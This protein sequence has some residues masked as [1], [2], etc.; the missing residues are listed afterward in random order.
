[1]RIEWNTGYPG[2]YD[3]LI[4]VNYFKSTNLYFLT[5]REKEG[6]IEEN[7]TLIAIWRIKL[8]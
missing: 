6:G 7:E 1:M 3:T 2:K 8:K 4:Y 5:A